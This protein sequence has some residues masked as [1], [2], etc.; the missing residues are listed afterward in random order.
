LSAAD[1]RNGVM[2]VIRR[3]GDRDVATHVQLFLDVAPPVKDLADYQDSLA[4]VMTHRRVWDQFLGEYPLVVGPNSGDLPVMIGFETRGQDAMRHLLAAQALMT[5][6][7]LLGL[8]AVAVPTGLVAAS[9]AP[10][11][12]PL[13]VQVIAP[14]FREDL[15]FDAAGIIEAALGIATPIDP[16]R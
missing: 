8:P 6:V 14:R 10:Q 15:A 2:D 1:I 16:V 9:D 3:Y 7:N 13:G 11:G 5:T 12:L 4:A